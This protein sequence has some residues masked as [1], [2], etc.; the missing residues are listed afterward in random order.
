MLWPDYR[1]RTREALKAED[2]YLSWVVVEPI[3]FFPTPADRSPRRPWKWRFV[4]KGQLLIYSVTWLEREVLNG[5]F[6][7]YFCNPSGSFF[8]DTLEGFERCGMRQYVDLLIE[9][10]HI[11][12]DGKPSLIRNERMAFIDRCAENQR[13]QGNGVDME[14]NLMV[15]NDFVFDGCNHRFYEIYGDG[16]EYYA[17]M[18][19][20]IRSHPEEFFK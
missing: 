11:F 13:A 16:N 9:A 19:R 12:P 15:V 17:R 1:L 3:W 6:A 7:Q 2:G 4:T 20:Y 8:V 18:A 10:A 5:G 14:E